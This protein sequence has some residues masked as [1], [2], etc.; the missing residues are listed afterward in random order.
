M[1]KLDTNV[2][3]VNIEN[4][5]MLLAR[6]HVGCS[7]GVCSTVQI[8]EKLFDDLKSR[9]VQLGFMFDVKQQLSNIIRKKY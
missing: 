8:E 2:N 9:D 5:K 3:D 7:T 4:R 6:V 1:L